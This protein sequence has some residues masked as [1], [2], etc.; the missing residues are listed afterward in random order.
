VIDSLL[1]GGRS[2]RLYKSLVKEKQLAVHVS[3]DA[4]VPGAVYPSL[5]T[6]QATPR[7]PHSTVELETGIYA[8]LDRLKNEPVDPHELQKVLNNLDADLIRS[9]DSNSGLSSRL[10]YFQAVAGSWRYLLENR[11]R[12]AHVKAEDVSRVARQYFVEKN[13]TVATLVKKE[14]EK[15]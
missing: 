14:E 4:G 12:I 13:R 3:T 6:I 8:E 1:S 5:F 10:S 2:S 7:A 9:L 11:D 15:K